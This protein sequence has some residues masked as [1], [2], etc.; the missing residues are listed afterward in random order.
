MVRHYLL[1]YHIYY[2]K[3]VTVS[4]KFGYRFSSGTK[5]ADSVTRETSSQM[6]RTAKKW[7]VTLDPHWYKPKSVVS[8]TT[9]HLNRTSLAS[10]QQR[11][12]LN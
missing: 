1:Y 8:I 6:H 5:M 12:L 10:L 3:P 4:S 11:A 9:S 2:R 7:P